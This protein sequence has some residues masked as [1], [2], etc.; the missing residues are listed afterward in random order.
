[1]RISASVKVLCALFLFIGVFFVATPAFAASKYWQATSSLLFN[2]TSNWTTTAGGACGANA[3]TTAPGASDIAI[4]QSTCDTSSTL[5]TA[6]N[7]AGIQIDSGY[8]GI[9]SQSTT[10]ITVGSSGFTQA[11]GTFTGSSTAVSITGAFNLSGGAFT[12]TASNTTFGASTT[13][14]GGTFS[15]NN[16]TA[17][18]SATSKTITPSST[19]FNNVTFSNNNTT[20]TVSGTLIVSGAFALSGTNNTNVINGG[21][22][23]M[24]GN[25]SSILNVISGTTSFIANGTS[26]QIY[27]APGGVTG[28]LMNLT[29]NKTAGTLFLNDI[30]QINTGGFTHT[31]GTVDAGTSTVVFS[32]T[33]TIVPGTIAFYNVRFNNSVSSFTVSSTPIIVNNL[34]ELG[35]NNNGMTIA[36]AGVEVCMVT[37]AWRRS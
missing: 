22:I 3:S 31:A 20:F 15:H 14:S 29:V 7:V 36:G 28:C 21:T 9:V 19:N 34:L 33:Q 13:I 5:N 26:T 24:R 23:E 25:F 12:A 17:I 6:V 10:T 16:G 11:D 37:S 8:T 32:G 4:F 2:N 35:G 1:M 30:L 27:T 18:F